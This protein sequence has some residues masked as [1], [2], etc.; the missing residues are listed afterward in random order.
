MRYINRW[1]FAE[2]RSDGES[3]RPRSRSSS[4]SRRRCPSSTANR[5]ARGFG[6]EQGLREGRLRQRDR[7]AAAAGRGR[8][9]SRDINY[10]TFR[11]ITPA[12]VCHGALASQ[13]VHRPD[14]RRRHHLRRRLPAVLEEEFEHDRTGVIAAADGGAIGRAGAAQPHRRTIRRDRARHCCGCNFSTGMARQL[15]FG[16]AALAAAAPTPADAKCRKD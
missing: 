13:P 11:W 14:P 12:Q 7:G 2:G 16:H 1:D 5:S 10:N 15:A 9:G 4:G 8:L 3:R 6:V